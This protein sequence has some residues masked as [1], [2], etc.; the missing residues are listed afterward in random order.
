MRVTKLEE[1]LRTMRAFGEA[2]NLDAALL[3][4][5][6]GIRV[7]WWSPAV[8]M[9]NYTFRIL[10]IVVARVSRRLRFESVDVCRISLQDRRN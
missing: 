8:N 4:V 1:T 3:H 10:D 5:T 2:R 7:D 9:A 6:W